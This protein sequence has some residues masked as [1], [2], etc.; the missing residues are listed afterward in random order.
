M[1][2]NAHKF[3]NVGGG[4]E[5]KTGWEGFSRE[6]MCWE[7]KEPYCDCKREKKIKVAAHGELVEDVGTVRVHINAAFVGSVWGLILFIFHSP[8]RSLRQGLWWGRGGA[9]VV[10]LHLSFLVTLPNYPYHKSLFFLPLTLF[11]TNM[12]G[13]NTSPRSFPGRGVSTSCRENCIQQSPGNPPF[14][15]QHPLFKLLFTPP[16]FF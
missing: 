8:I 9:L 16:P 5:I 2:I 6:S 10:V 14:S 1:L 11:S 3:K 4:N 7:E 13:F 12:H 15:H